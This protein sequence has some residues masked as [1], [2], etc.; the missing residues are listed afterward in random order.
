MAADLTVSG[1][2]NPVTVRRDRWWHRRPRVRDGIH[3]SVAAMRLGIDIPVR[4]GEP[5]MEGYGVMDEYTVTPAV[6]V[7]DDSGEL[8]DRVL[9]LSSFR[10]ADGFWM[11]CDTASGNRATGEV[12]L[13]LPSRP[14]R[15]EEIAAEL[16]ERLRE[17][18]IDAAVAFNEEV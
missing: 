14:H 5:E 16:T 12:R 13:C 11:R 6:P 2:E 15:R 3:R 8:L 4:F 18:G 10:S 9:S 17:A 7:A 1:F